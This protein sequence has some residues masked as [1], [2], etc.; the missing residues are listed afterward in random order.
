M[1]LKP[2]HPGMFVQTEV[3]EDMGLEIP[4]IAKILGVPEA[5]SFRFREREEPFV[6]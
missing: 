1:N 2:A 6:S 5:D 4:Q 3:I